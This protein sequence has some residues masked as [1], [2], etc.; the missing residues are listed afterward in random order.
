MTTKAARERGIVVYFEWD[1]P[2][3]SSAI[4]KGDVAACVP[5]SGSNPPAGCALDPVGPASYDLITGL[6][7]EFVKSEQGVIDGKK[8]AHFGG[9]EFGGSCW[10][11]D[12]KIMAFAKKNHLT[13]STG[14]FN[15][16]LMVLH[17]LC[18]PY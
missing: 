15:L 4:C 3:H 8:L 11:T 18:P 1:M 9:D 14:G 7:R 10:P 12:P 17:S 16:T 2:G 6:L 5:W 13:N